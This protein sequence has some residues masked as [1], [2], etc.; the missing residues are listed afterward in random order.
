MVSIF[1]SAAPEQSVW[2]KNPLVL[3]IG[4]A[5]VSQLSTRGHFG[6]DLIEPPREIEHR[7]RRAAAVRPFERKLTAANLVDAVG[8]IDL[9][10][11]AFGRSV[12]P[13][14]DALG[15]FGMAVLLC[16]S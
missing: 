11:A 15:L 6:V 10:R 8:D 7:H 5:I 14:N 12:L 3:A 2:T 13:T 9:H 4:T 16:S 1:H